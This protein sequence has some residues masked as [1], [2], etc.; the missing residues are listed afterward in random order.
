MDGQE[1][2]FFE[3]I[4]SRQNFFPRKTTIKHKKQFTKKYNNTNKIINNIARTTILYPKD[5]FRT[6]DNN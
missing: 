5:Y 6:N 3:P 1:T 4:L 2:R